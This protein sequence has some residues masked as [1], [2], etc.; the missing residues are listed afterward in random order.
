MLSTDGSYLVTKVIIVKEVMTYDVSP[1]A[2]FICVFGGQILG[3]IVF[4]VL[5]P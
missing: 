1:V 4:E 5:R 3:N 2:M